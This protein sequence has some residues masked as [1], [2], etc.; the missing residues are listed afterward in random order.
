MVSYW[1][2]FFDALQHPSG[3]A[4][5]A[6]GGAFTSGITYVWKRI[7]AFCADIDKFSFERKNWSVNFDRTKT[8]GQLMSFFLYL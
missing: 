3:F 4:T 5:F 8:K 7:S 1:S 6:F 2:A